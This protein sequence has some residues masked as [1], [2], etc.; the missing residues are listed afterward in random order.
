MKD[1]VFIQL[2][3]EHGID[4]PDVDRIQIPDHML[5][6]FSSLLRTMR[7]LGLHREV[8]VTG[9]SITAERVRIDFEM[10]RPVGRH[11]ARDLH[12]IMCR[13]E[14]EFLD[15]VDEFQEVLR[16]VS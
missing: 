13:A 16:N 12:L 1:S 15:V 6:V 5:P 3:K 2:L 9:I 4:L 10:R 7:R 11:R 14:A 8:R